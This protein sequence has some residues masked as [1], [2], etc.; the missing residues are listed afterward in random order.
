MKAEAVYGSL[1]ELTAS[2]LPHWNMKEPDEVFQHIFQLRD[3]SGRGA[4]K[5]KAMTGAS[6][7]F[8]QSKIRGGR[9][10]GLQPGTRSK[11]EEG[12]E[13]EGEKGG[14]DDQPTSILRDASSTT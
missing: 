6:W 12:E 11:T 7:G 5:S 14:G 13:K 3:D 9:G 2:Q 8:R 1:E 4:G 10:S